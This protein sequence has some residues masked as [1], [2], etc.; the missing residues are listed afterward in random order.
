MLSLWTLNERS[1]RLL[2]VGERLPY[3]TSHTYSFTL[4]RSVDGP[5]SDNFFYRS[6]TRS[7]FPGNGG[8]VTFAHDPNLSEALTGSFAI[9]VKIFDRGGWD[10][11]TNS[12]LSPASPPPASP[13]PPAGSGGGGGS[14]G[15]PARAVQAAH[16]ARVGSNHANRAL[17]GRFS[18]SRTWVDARQARKTELDLGKVK[19]VGG[20][21]LVLGLFLSHGSVFVGT[22]GALGEA[23]FVGGVGLMGV[24]AVVALGA[25]AAAAYLGTQ[26]SDRSGEGRT[27][28]AL[29]GSTRELAA[30]KVRR[31]VALPRK[32]GLGDLSSAQKRGLC[33]LAKRKCSPTLITALKTFKENQARQAEIVRAIGISAERHAT[34][35][36][37]GD[38]LGQAIQAAAFNVY[39]HLLQDRSRILA[40]NA[41]AL[42]KGFRF[43]GFS[44]SRKVVTKIKPAALVK[45][46]PR[47]QV[48]RLKSA[49]ITKKD[50]RAEI[51]Y[52]VFATKARKIKISFP[53]ILRQLSKPQRYTRGF[54]AAGK[55]MTL[56]EVQVIPDALRA[57]RALSKEDADKLQRGIDQAAALTDTCMKKEA[58]S[59]FARSQPQVGRDFI[60]AATSA[61]ASGLP[62]QV[63]TL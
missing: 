50:L 36:R 6:A 31:Q 51:A 19:H 52:A 5:R 13:P 10:C 40:I 4:C 37:A 35:V 46:I 9:T 3:D 53:W 38:D 15:C 17:T 28:Q 45:T 39:G 8:I 21:T 2:T 34:A 26:E 23:A 48:R 27:R 60:R 24:G 59:V 61:W 56:G 11:A 12:P 55:S 22:T 18:C 49:G 41:R 44:L 54:R 33:S 30:A 32:V 43:G 1:N 57:Q 25:T 62:F 16:A 47:A 7:A 29:L 63:C 58:L 42:Q 14:T 20:A